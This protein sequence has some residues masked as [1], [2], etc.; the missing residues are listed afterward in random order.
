M[1][2][3]G[4][5]NLYFIRLSW[6]N[7]LSITINQATRNLYQTKS[8]RFNENLPTIKRLFHLDQD[9]FYIHNYTCLKTS[10]TFYH[11]FSI[12]IKSTVKLEARVFFPNI[13]LLLKLLSQEPISWF[14]WTK[15]WVT[16]GKRLTCWRDLVVSGLV[17]VLHSCH[18][19]ALLHSR[20]HG[21]HDPPSLPG[22]NCKSKAGWISVLLWM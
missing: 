8:T 16:C 5:S 3:L 2:P 18:K 21:S 10:I 12:W 17:P 9:T 20:K 11:D 7:K 22:S 4:R 13:P 1:W 14:S 15:W 19:P 6:L